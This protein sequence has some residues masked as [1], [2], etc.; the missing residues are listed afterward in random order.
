MQSF[1]WLK[2]W[3][4]A[5]SLSV[6]TPSTFAYI[7][8]TYTSD[9]LIW[10]TSY[11]DKQQTKEQLNFFDLMQF[12]FSFDVDESL[13]SKTETT[14]V[15]I[16]DFTLTPIRD[17]L[18]GSSGFEFGYKARGRVEINP[19]K[20]INFWYILFDVNVID[21][22]GYSDEFNRATNH[23]MTINSFGG[24]NTCNCDLFQDRFYSLDDNLSAV[25][26]LESRF[27]NRSSFDNWTLSYHV[28]ESNGL[29]L[30][31]IGLLGLIA[32]RRQKADKL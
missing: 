18:E 16:T 13:L 8:Y 17:A 25:A 10:R 31:A 30:V 27:G 19:D 26:H 1:R 6:V 9:P 4:L 15:L 7:Q 32:I 14:S 21:A 29:A 5:L 11:L 23:R 20:T 22:L 2:L 28:P 3:F 24:A 12:E